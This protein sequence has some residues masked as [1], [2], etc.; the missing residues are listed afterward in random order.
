MM[1]AGEM[2]MLNMSVRF[3]MMRD[4]KATKPG[5]KSLISSNL[6]EIGL[7]LNSGRHIANND[8]KL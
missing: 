7:G 4:L 3:Y 8:R 1:E 2:A 5:S 6:H